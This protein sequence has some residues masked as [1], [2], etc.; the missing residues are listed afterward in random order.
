MPQILPVM[1]TDLGK[2]FSSGEPPNILRFLHL[3]G[4]GLSYLP[5]KAAGNLRVS[6]FQRNE[7]ERKGGC[8][9]YTYKGIVYQVVINHN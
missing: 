9:N 1:S 4:G 2:F 8:F 5:D 3:P 6:K 7:V